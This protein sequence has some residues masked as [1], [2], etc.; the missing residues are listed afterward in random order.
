M[1]IDRGKVVRLSGGESLDLPLPFCLQIP[2]VAK[3]QYLIPSDFAGTLNS[4]GRFHPDL[5]AV[6]VAP[7]HTCSTRITG[8]TTC[9]APSP[10]LD[11]RL[12]ASLRLTRLP[13]SLLDPRD[14]HE[15]PS[16]T[17]FPFREHLLAL[18]PPSHLLP[19]P[20]QLIDHVDPWQP[21]YRNSRDR[22][23]DSKFGV[24]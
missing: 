10:K 23:E 24:R 3:I 19:P 4:C 18:P 7:I 1:N 22:Q 20:H 5:C 2:K 14:W 16:H 12:C 8:P 21:L 6:P 15:S 17:P 9:L 11:H 13:L